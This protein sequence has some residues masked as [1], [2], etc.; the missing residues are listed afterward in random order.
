MVADM[1]VEHYD[2]LRERRKFKAR[3]IVLL[4]YIS[5]A[6]ALTIDRLLGALMDYVLGVFR[7]G[8]S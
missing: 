5:I 8:K 4:H 3:W 2:A 6:R 1:R 7:A